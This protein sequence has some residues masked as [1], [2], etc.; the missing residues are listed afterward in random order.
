MFQDFYRCPRLYYYR[1]ILGLVSAGVSP[2]LQFGSLL[3]AA[4]EVWYTTRDPVATLTA[5]DE[6]EDFTEPDDDH[7]TRGRARVTIAEYIELF[8][9]ESLQM[10]LTETPFDLEDS[11]GFR[12]GGVMDGL[13]M[14]HGKLWALDHKSTARGGETFW[15]QF[16]M[17]PQM[18]GYT[19]AASSLHGKKVMGALVNQILI[20]RNKKPA[21]E[22]FNRRS[23]MYSEGQI[24]EWKDQV[25]HNYRL[26]H[27][28]QQADHFPTQ[29]HGCVNKYGKCAFYNVCRSPEKSRPALLEKDFVHN[30]WH[31]DKEK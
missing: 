1:H 9:E 15:D 10:L 21:H 6:Y 16:F 18:T 25:C 28:C 14:W 30:P 22:Q 31:W 5:V 26:I 2:A 11:D 17:S 24:A 3:H 19:W 20:H 4:L 23:F 8:H 27:Q 13:V 29:W 12:Y 7:R